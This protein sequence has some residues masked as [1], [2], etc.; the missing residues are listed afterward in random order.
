MAG[1]GDGNRFRSTVQQHCDDKAAG[2]GIWRYH[3]LVALTSFV[4][5]IDTVRLP[6]RALSALSL[7]WLDLRGL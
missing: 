7:V 1:A 5:L 6:L 4:S 3:W 2:G